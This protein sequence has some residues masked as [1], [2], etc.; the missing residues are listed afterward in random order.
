[1][2]NFK[3]TKVGKTTSVIVGLATA[4]WLSVGALVAPMT[5]L[6]ATT[7][8]TIASLLAQITQ[9]QAQLASLQTGS[10]GG[11]TATKCS[12]TRSLTVGSK[13]EDVTCLQKYLQTTGHY[14]FSGG[15]T[16]YFGSVTK[17]AVAA[18]Q[19]ANGVSPAAGYFGSLSQAKYSSLVSSSSSSSVSSVSSSVSSGASSSASSVATGEGLT[20]STATQPVATLAVEGAARL[21][22]TKVTLTA[23]SQDITVTGVTVERTGLANDAVFDGIVLLDENGAQLGISKTLNSD[24]KATIGDTV[25]I[26]AGQ[27]KTF[28]VAGNMDDDGSTATNALTSYA[29]QVAYL[30]VTGVSTSATV[31]GSLPITGAGHTINSSLAIGSVS[32]ARGSI[33]PATSPTKPIGTTGYTFSAVKFTAGSAEKIKVKSIRWN[34]SGSAAT[35]DLANVKTYIDG[36]AYDTTVSSDGKYYTATFGDGIVVDKGGNIEISVKGDIVGGSGRTIDFDIYKNTD[37]Y[38]TGETYGYGIT[39]PNGGSDPAD[40]SSNFS[41]TNPWYDASQVEV[42]AGTI[43]VTKA[44]SVAAQN[45]AE[46][47]ANQPLGGFIVEVKGEPIS[48]NN[49]IFNFLITGTGGQVADITN[50]SLYDENGSVVAGPADGSGAAAYGTVTFSDTVTFPVGTKTYTLKGKLGTDFANDQTV[51]ASTTPS[52]NW[53]NV[54]GQ[55]TGNSIT[56]SSITSSV[57]TGNTMTLKTAAMTISVSSDPVAQTVVSGAQGFTFAKYVL[58]AAASGEDVKFSSLPLAYEIFGGTATNVNNC[59]L[60]DGSTAL[61][62]GSNV[63]NPSAAGSST[64]FTLDS[65]F[66]VSKGTSKTLTLKCNII[67]GATGN[68]AWGYDSGASPTITGVTSGQSAGLTENDSTG[69]MMTL[70]ANGTL[71]VTANTSLSPA[72]NAVASAGTS[73]VTLGVIDFHAANE[74]INLTKLGLTLTNTASSSA[75]NF[76]TSG[77]NGAHLTLWDG[78]T[79]VGSLTLTGAT[80]TSTLTSDFIIPKD[81]DKTLTIKGDLSDIGTSQAGTQG[82]LIAVNYIGAGNAQGTGQSS[83][84]SL[85]S[86]SGATS[87]SSTRVFKSYPTVARLSGIESTLAGT[88][89]ETVMGFSVTAD[90]KGKIALYKLA[91]NVATTGVTADSLNVYAYNSYSSG[92]FSSPVSG[93]GSGGKMLNT[94]ADLETLWAAASTDI[95]V[96]PQTTAGASTTIEIAAGATMYFKVV[97]T[98]TGVGSGDSMT[99][100]LRG[101]NA[102]PSLANLMGNYVNIEA[103]GTAANNFIWSPRATS[104]TVSINDLDW[105]NGYN[106]AS[107]PSSGISF[108]KSK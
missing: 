53:S 107:L 30:S 108:T 67:A 10:T 79:K 69:Q 26:K 99:V 27:S 33:D 102:Y 80:G 23:G 35:S 25:T 68:Y 82:A 96:Y 16:G 87:L 72:A 105:T 21:P 58:D 98:I 9:L 38:I 101:D 17:S 78:S 92:T 74:A 36:T 29:G 19:A 60:Y 54:T 5:T 57:V 73:G 46:N 48:A 32:N 2:N 77:T 84:V 103:A 31:S 50:I 34:Q 28:T 85:T 15:A 13:G 47:V 14:T 49:L 88:T 1:M 97:A 81:G 44:T 104:T 45:V 40:D 94:D 39:A 64:S 42:S 70:T 91:F 4:A 56:G 51:V 62:T 18:W 59:I 106:V 7:E 66:T 61:N 22:F 8:E 3:T 63:V 55:T 37:V 6:A 52:S 20:I 90:S 71:T 75:S 43:T 89:D 41:S 83:G 76:T 95:E 100:T 12:F 86:S 93:I 11:S 65:A 24:H